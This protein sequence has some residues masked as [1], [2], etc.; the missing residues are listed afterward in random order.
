MTALLLL[1]AQ[2]LTATILPA[3]PF[4]IEWRHTGEWTPVFRFWCDGAIV[5]NFR[6]TEP[7]RSA[8]RG[9]DG[10]YTYTATVPGLPVGAHPCFVSA[11][12][13]AAET[14]GEAKGEP[15]MFMVAV[16]Q[17]IPPVPLKLKLIVP[18]IGG[19]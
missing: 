18:V 15:V 12:N 8:T 6:E 17:Q 14:L 13:G 19:A 5:K 3:T 11:Y 1:L 10:L 9:A 16:P 4:Q 7:M 2:T